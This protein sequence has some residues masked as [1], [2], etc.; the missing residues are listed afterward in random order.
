MGRFLKINPDDN[1]V[2]CLDPLTKGDKINV[3]DITI[4]AKEDIPAGHKMAIKDI[5]NGGNI[6]KYGFAIGHT[7]ENVEQGRW[8]HTHD[9][10]TNLEGILTYSYNPD[11]EDIANK[12]K[13]MA[14]KNRTFE[15]FVRKDG[16]VGIRNE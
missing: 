2:V 1:V 10:K 12:E 4:T 3:G 16:K 15:G 8:I 6:I 5:E 13:E 9:L 14:T 7:T 11:K